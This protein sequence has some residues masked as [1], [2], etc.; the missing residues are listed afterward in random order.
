VRVP[1]GTEVE[2]VPFTAIR[3]VNAV[4]DKKPGDEDEYGPFR[5]ELVQTDGTSLPLATYPDPDHAE[6]LAGWLRERIG[7]APLTE[8]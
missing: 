4:G 5:C 6:A 3:A 1:V 2:E 8:I 7:L